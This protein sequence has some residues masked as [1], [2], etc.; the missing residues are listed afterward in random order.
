MRIANPYINKRRI[1]DP[2]QRVADPPQRVADP[3]HQAVTE[4]PSRRDDLGWNEV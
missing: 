2:P 4:H 1:S 3:P